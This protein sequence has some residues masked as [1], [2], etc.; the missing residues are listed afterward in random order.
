MKTIPQNTSTSQS[1]TARTRRLRLAAIAGFTISVQ[2]LS[3]AGLHAAEINAAP[4]EWLVNSIGVNVHLGYTDTVYWNFDA[5]RSRLRALGVRHIR[6]GVSSSRPEYYDRMKILG[7]DGIRLT[8]ICST[9]V[10]ATQIV[11]NADRF[12]LTATNNMIEAFEGPN[13][14]DKNNITVSALRS[15]QHALWDAVNLSGFQS[16]PVLGPSITDQIY[17]NSV[18]SAGGIGAWMDYGNIHPYPGGW[19]PENGNLITAINLGRTTCGPKQL[20]ATETGYTN[21]FGQSLHQ[22]ITERATGIFLPR[23]YFY[24]LQQ[25]LLRTFWYELYDLRVDNGTVAQNH[26]GLYRND[27]SAKPAAIALQNLI[28]LLK[29]PGPTFSAGSL[30]FTVTSGF[31]YKLLKKRTGE[32]WI[33]IWRPIRLWDYSPF[34]QKQE[35]YNSPINCTLTIHRTVTNVA[36]YTDL[37]SGLNPTPRNYGTATTVNIGIADSLVL[38]RIQVPAL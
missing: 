7:G 27:G 2:L 37:H 38:F 8:A 22:P 30:D 23:L 1:R 19:H 36:A 32:C 5:A 24:Y 18:T 13:E 31:S 26:F 28:G 34:G 35:V 11:A 20:Y 6:D 14:P 16:R 29:D 9:S 4:T 17:A 3:S 12:S 10:P 15:Y 21:A 25:G 33:A